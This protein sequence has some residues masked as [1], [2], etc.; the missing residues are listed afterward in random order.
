MET[1][2]RSSSTCAEAVRDDECLDRFSGVA[3]AGRDDL[4]GDGLQVVSRGRGGLG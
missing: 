3:A 1:E 2:A 4:V